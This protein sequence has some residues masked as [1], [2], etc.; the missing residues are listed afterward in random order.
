MPD[1]PERFLLLSASTAGP[2]PGILRMLRV[3]SILLAAAGLAG[4]YVYVPVDASRPAPAALSAPGDPPAAPAATSAKAAEVVAGSELRV[5]VG[6]QYR[7]ELHALLGWEARRVEGALVEWSG[8]GV[9]LDVA[10]ARS[11][12]G[13]RALNQRLLV[14]WS[15]VLEVEEKRLHRGRTYALL[16]GIGAAAVLGHRFLL[17]GKAGGDAGGEPPVDADFI[18]VPHR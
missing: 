11:R 14:P 4:C 15:E 7:N 2:T 1:E 5:H 10:V 8:E 12:D 17:G 16:A 9:A 18:N 13:G 6:R 3:V